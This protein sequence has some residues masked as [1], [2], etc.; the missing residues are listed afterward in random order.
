MKIIKNLNSSKGNTSSANTKPL[1]SSIEKPA[2]P[3]QKITSI[4]KIQTQNNLAIQQ[5][6]LINDGLI[7]DGPYGGFG[8]TTLEKFPSKQTYE[9][10]KSAVLDDVSAK[11]KDD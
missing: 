1:N 8:V 4:D 9:L 2:K 10:S 3:G 6:I 11:N 7:A 5:H